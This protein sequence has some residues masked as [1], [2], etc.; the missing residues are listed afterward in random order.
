MA[1]RDVEHDAEQNRHGGGQQSDRT[2][3]H[4]Q[5][6]PEEAAVGRVA[7]G[8]PRLIVGGERSRKYQ[9]LRPVPD[10]ERTATGARPK[11]ATWRRDGSPIQAV[12]AP[13][14]VRPGTAPARLARVCCAPAQSAEPACWRSAV[15]SCCRAP[16]RSPSRCSRAIR[17]RALA[18]DW[19]RSTRTSG[20]PPRPSPHPA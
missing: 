4:G 2:A 12:G 20:Y 18:A 5:H 7:A 15:C 11:G 8:L 6:V 9:L 19:R 17:R 3:A 10:G 13:L 1:V 16:S 14:V